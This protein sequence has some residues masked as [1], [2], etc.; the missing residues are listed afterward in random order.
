[1]EEKLKQKRMNTIIL[2]MST[3]K[4]PESPLKKMEVCESYTGYLYLLLTT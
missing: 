1:M 3:G 4:L 2:N